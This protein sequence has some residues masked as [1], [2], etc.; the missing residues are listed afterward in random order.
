MKN[1]LG[2]ILITILLT[3]NASGVVYAQTGQ[4]QEMVEKA[5]SSIPLY[6]LGTIGLLLTGGICFFAYKLI[7]S[8]TTKAPPKSRF[9]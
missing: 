3:L 4:K 8:F 5:P 9:K 1:K 7:K 6:I 2:Q